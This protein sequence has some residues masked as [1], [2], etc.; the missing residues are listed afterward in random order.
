MNSLSQD[1][2]IGRI[3]E[4]QPF[5]VIDGGMDALLRQAEMLAAAIRYY[6]LNDHQ[7]GYF[8]RFLR[9]LVCIRETGVDRFIPDGNL[10]PSQALLLTFIRQLSEIAGQFNLRWKGYADWYLHT[11]LG[12]KPLRMESHKVC[13]LFS[14]NTDEPVRMEKGL[15]FYPK[16][17]APGAPVYRLTEDMEVGNA[18]I[19]D[20]ISIYFCKRKNMYPAS[21]LGFVT[22]LRMKRLSGEPAGKSLLFG[23]GSEDLQNAGNLGFILAAPSLL[24]REGKRTVSIVLETENKDEIQAMMDEIVSTLSQRDGK[25]PES[26]R[27]LVLH[28][29]FCLFFSASE[30]WEAVENYS[31]K[32]EDGCVA[33][34][35]TLDENFPKTASCDPGVHHF[36]S[37]FPALKAELNLDAW[38]Y[39]FSWFNKCLLKKIRIRTEVEGV[40]NLLVY[41]NLGKVDCS[42]PF[43][44]FGNNTEKGTWMA[45]G[46]YETAIKNTQSIDL[47]IRWGQ[48]P[49]DANGLRGYYA[50]YGCEVDNTSFRVQAKYLSGYRWRADKEYPLF[51]ALTDAPL[52]EETALQGINTSKMPAVRLREEQYEYTINTEAGMVALQL[53]APEMGFGE[54]QYRTAFSDSIL[55][56]ALHIKKKVNIPNP[57]LYPVVEKLTLNYTAEETIDLQKDASTGQLAYYHITPLTLRK[58]FPNRDR[59]FFKPVF[60]METHANLLILLKDL[61]LG[62]TLR[63][64]IDFVPHKVEISAGQ[65]PQIKLYLG[66]GY[67]WE[68]VPN[69]F[70]VEDKTM[71]LLIS[72]FI[73]INIPTDI[74]SSLFDASGRIWLRTGVVKNVDT[75]PAIRKIYTHVAEAE[76]N[77]GTGEE[78]SYCR[79]PDGAE[80]QPERAVN[81]LTGVFTVASYSGRDSESREERLMRVSEYAAHRGKAVTARDYERIVLQAFPDIAKVKCLPSVNVKNDAKNV[82]TLVIVPQRSKREKEK[83]RTPLATSRQILNVEQYLS[84]LV[85]AY[86]TGV[87]VI[88]PLYE[89]VIARCSVIFKKRY[90]E[91]LCHTRVTD[92]LDS[93]IAPWQKT[94]AQPVFDCPLDMEEIYRTLSEQDFVEEIKHFSMVVIGEKTEHSYNLYEYGRDAN[95]ILPSTPYSVFV[96]SGKHILVS[97]DMENAFGIQE[98]TIGDSFIIS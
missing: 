30:G 66:N 32:M 36:Q 3:R 52:C 22:S 93:L 53:C 85:S 57:P 42:K 35:F 41:N 39:P 55:E 49:A 44:P 45:V 69:D 37:E 92:L 14:T 90:P 28:D 70:I 46:S 26:I 87:D 17:D 73:K 4:V 94:G 33:L 88:N 98:M 9:D 51:G 81:G 1:D 6:D 97:S 61:P 67:A 11:I 59:R 18:G 62:G 80:W 20:I 47:K 84:G 15:G 95:R 27:Y 7:D 89:E 74:S 2:R 8:D 78:D 96:P 56:K 60:E 68:P 19:E 91:A 24:L 54:K 86:V 77:P 43:Q 71:N 13:L 63:L 65:I 50:G 40:S 79:L 34:R 48:L 75:I 38:L 5:A 16:G 12:I 31:V 82:V 25:S 64:Y 23:D 72:G 29:I 10:E 76:F 21:E 83:Y 58:I